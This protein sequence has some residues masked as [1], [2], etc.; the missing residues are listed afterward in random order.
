MENEVTSVK[1]YRLMLGAPVV[2]PYLTQLAEYCEITRF[3][4]LLTPGVWPPEEETRAACMG[5][6]IVVLEADRLSRATLSDW[7][8]SGLKLL[9]CTRGNPSNVDAAA[10]KE[11]GIPLFHTPGRNA[12]S[13]A[14]YTLTLMLMLQK[15]IATALAGI[16]DGRY[17]DRAVPDI[18]DVTNHTDVVWMND[19]V[20]VYAMQPLGEELYGR[21]LGVV[22]FGAIGRRVAAMATAFGMR[23]LAYDPYCAPSMIEAAGAECLSL[24]GVLSESD[25]LSIHLPVTP[26]TIGLVDE[27][28]FARMKPGVKLINTARA[29]VI[30]QQAMLTA[31]ETGKLAGAA[32]DVMWIEP[33]PKNHPFLAMDNVIVLPHQAGATVDIDRW[34]SS[35]VLEE[36]E[37]FLAGRPLTHPFP[38]G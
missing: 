32:V 5:A 27:S 23:V 33:C 29:A 30:D 25:I 24:D 17:L 2:E 31:L 19:R 7:K 22:G 36:V 21:T 10:C 9:G 14:E 1:K 37:N 11:L 38:R 15:K 4:Q 20:N 8:S 16:R 26:A 35:M 34:Q 13:V 6:D 28:W 3:S 18:L 12:Q